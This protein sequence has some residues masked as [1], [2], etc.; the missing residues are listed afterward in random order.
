MVTSLATMSSVSTSIGILQKK[1]LEAAKQWCMHMV[2]V[3]H[4]Q[5][6]I[7]VVFGRSHTKLYALSYGKISCCANTYYMLLM[8][9]L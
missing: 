8:A 3:K 4:A 6:C 1:S 9:A 2:P 7:D 5:A